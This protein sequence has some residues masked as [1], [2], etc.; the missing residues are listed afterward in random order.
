MTTIAVSTTKAINVAGIG[1]VELTVEEQGSGRPYLVLHG[2]AGPQSVAR[3][4][5]LLAEKDR[6]RVLTPIHPGFGDTPRPEE[7]NS[8][9]KLAA[10]YSGL[11]DELGLDD[12]TVIGNSVGGWVA[13]E[14]A[15]LGSPRISGIVLLDAVGI[16]WRATPSPTSPVSRARNP[17]TL[18]PRPDAIPRRS[19]HHPRH[20]EVNHGR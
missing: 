19:H 1:P 16:E 5:Q 17:G 13:A 11:L 8:V 20:P 3:L 15:L 14:M 9:A 10:L 18:I 6:N 12:V 4:A 2:G 7:L